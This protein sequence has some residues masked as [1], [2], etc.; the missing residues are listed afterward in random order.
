MSFSSERDS[1]T[2]KVKLGWG[3]ICHY[4]LL[5]GSMKPTLYVAHKTVTLK[6]ILTSINNFTK[7]TGYGW[8]FVLRYWTTAF[9]LSWV[10]MSTHFYNRKGKK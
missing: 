4:T 8:N 7:I 10:L 3:L 1:P 5:P 6:S 9:T 2:D